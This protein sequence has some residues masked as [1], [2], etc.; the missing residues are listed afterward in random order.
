MD[1]SAEWEIFGFYQMSKSLAFEGLTATVGGLYVGDVKTFKPIS[2]KWQAEVPLLLQ[3]QK[4]DEEMEAL[5]KKEEADE[6]AKKREEEEIARKEAN[7]K[8]LERMELE[9][10]RNKDGA[11]QFTAQAT[12]VFAAVFALAFWKMFKIDGR[13]LIKY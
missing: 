4:E 5:K 13:F 1:A 11:T 7:K 9:S 8:V 12:A 2:A 3:K 10:Q 6:A